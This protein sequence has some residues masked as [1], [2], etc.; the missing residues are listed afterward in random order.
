MVRK[1]TKKDSYLATWFRC[2][3]VI[4]ASLVMV[5]IYIS[6]QWAS[7]VAV[8]WSA[9]H[10]LKL[11]GQSLEPGDVINF[12]GGL[13][14]FVGREEVF[15]RDG[16]GH[17]GMYL[18]RDDQGVPKFLDFQAVDK[19]TYLS[20]KKILTGDEFVYRYYS[21]DPDRTFDVFRPQAKVPAERLLA[22][23]D[24]LATNFK[25]GLEKPEVEPKPQRRMMCSLAVIECL[26]R[27][28]DRRI[29]DLGADERF[30][31]DRFMTTTPNGFAD[32]KVLG[33]FFRKVNTAPL[34]MPD[35]RGAALERA[36]KWYQKTIRKAEDA[37]Q[38]A[39]RQLEKS[40]HLLDRTEALL[41]KASPSDTR[42][43]A[44]AQ[45]A[46]EKARSNISK[47]TRMRKETCGRLEKLR[48]QLSRVR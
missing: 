26:K 39:T 1:A 24:Y 38:R 4:G 21:A 18:G 20:E 33:K 22:T 17:T 16:Y 5:L 40:R 28:T 9:D 19:D 8:A 41:Q 37:C 45:Q 43:R 35:I 30:I 32:P 42:G 7:Q 44:I 25:F 27:A 23:A 13:F 2:F 11:A 29:T 48:V 15:L 10:T 46:A 6:L 31:V 14:Q 3:A 34:K 36:R 12:R 47:Y